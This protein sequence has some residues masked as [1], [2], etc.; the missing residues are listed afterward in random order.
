MLRTQW[1]R[2]VF[3]EEAQKIESR[4]IFKKEECLGIIV[5]VTSEQAAIVRRAVATTDKD[6]NSWAS[7]T[8]QARCSCDGQNASSASP[9]IASTPTMAAA[10]EDD[11][12]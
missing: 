9:P 6:F 4:P 11:A 8:L 1:L 7:G 2:K 5:R 10:A 12:G 3:V